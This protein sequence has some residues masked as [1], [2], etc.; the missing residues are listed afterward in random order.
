MDFAAFQ[1]QPGMISLITAGVFVTS[2]IIWWLVRKKR[3]RVWLPTLRILKQE[4]S[5]LPKLRLV[6][7]PLIFFLCFFLASLALTIFTFRPSQTL[8]Q[9]AEPGH[10]KT[11]IFLD[12]SPSVF[13]GLSL[14]EYRQ[15][16]LNVYEHY[17]KD[18]TITVSSSHSS[19][20]T[21][22]E[23]IDHFQTMMAP[24]EPH[25]AGLK[26]GQAM[27]MVLE[28]LGNIDRLVIVSDGSQ[29]TWAD[30]NWQYLESKFEILHAP[31]R[32]SS[33]RK[34]NA[35]IEDVRFASQLDDS[36]LIWEVDIARAHAGDSVSGGLQVS[37]GNDQLASAEWRM[38]PNQ[39]ASTVTVEVFRDGLSEL[40]LSDDE[41]LVWRID[42][43]SPEQSL[44]GLD[45]EF[46]TFFSGVRQD[47]LLISEP[48]G[49]MFLEDPV[50][51]LR[52]AL[53]LLG[54]DVKRIDRV[55]EPMDQSYYDYPL[56]IL[57]GG[58]SAQ[59]QDFCPVG[60]AKRRIEARRTGDSL[61]EKPRMPKLWMLPMSVQANYQQLCHCFAS[62]VERDAKVLEQLPPYC[63]DVEIRD[64][65]ISVL[66][67]LGARQ[68]GGQ[69]DRLVDALAWHRRESD[70]GFELLA[71]TLPLYP[72]SITGISYSQ[73][74][75]LV[76]TLADWMGFLKDH[77]LDHRNAWPRVSDIS[78]SWEDDQDEIGIV[79]SNVPRGESM[80][81][82]MEP[83]SLPKAWRGLISSSPQSTMGMQ[84]E[85]DPRPWIDIL[86]FIILVLIGIEGALIIMNSLLRLARKKKEYASMLLICFLGVLESK[87]HAD[88]Q[89]NLLGY[90][91]E[92]YSG[93]TLARDVVGRTS[94]EM[95]GSLVHSHSISDQIFEEG[96]IWANRPEDLYDANG[97]VDPKIL[98]WMKRGG[99][100]VVENVTSPEQLDFD[101]GRLARD[102]G[103]RTIP[104]DHEIMRSFHLLDSLPGCEDRLWYGYNFDDRI[105]VIAI[106]FSLLEG[107]L[108][109]MSANSCLEQLGRERATRIFINIIM[110]A[111]ATDYKKDQIHLPEILKRL[112]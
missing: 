17:Q 2:L 71:F 16:A 35:Y 5:Q 25:R 13:Y 47:V 8:Y 32:Q 61:L 104:P 40:G 107:L 48:Q 57:S 87:A 111:L 70:L 94:I 58:S 22:I 64:Q 45:H 31:V 91:T 103:W 23:N 63:E 89:M 75:F 108:K 67:S 86:L 55:P 106:P 21:Q 53:E 50:H 100:L 46:R 18:S 41:P 93:Q 77:S 80:L 95:A 20:I 38:L 9:S 4:A 6:P 34:N 51:H 109:D 39:S 97:Q 102:E 68:I 26:L 81:R 24:L 78:A 42:F 12:M 74:P 60:L 19:Q 92:R 79:L 37:F 73:L 66:R 43:D 54:F 85:Q 84:E 69:V 44:L 99:F 112:R 1:M 82:E 101:L 110:V 59:V 7:P 62:F 105:A 52:I 88:V 27:H 49:E 3:Q 14:D 76:R 30:F 98:S 72:S 33:A 28:S 36:Q 29:Y 15:L 83:G 56:W 10:R 90:P 65:Y 11:H 96:W